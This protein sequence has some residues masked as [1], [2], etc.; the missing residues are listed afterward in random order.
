MLNKLRG[1]FNYDAASTST[2][3]RNVTTTIK[4]TDDLLTPEKRQRLISNANDLQR[5]YSIAAW[6]IRRHLDYVS[7]FTFHPKTGNGPLDADIRDLMG[8]YERAPNCDV[9]ERHTLCRLV[10]LLE[11]R[12]TIDGDVFVVRRGDGR[13]QAV[14]SDRV[15]N[16]P[17]ADAN[18]KHG[19]KLSDAGAMTQIAVHKR[20]SFGGYV[21]DRNV[22]GRNVQ[23][24][25]YFDRL[26]QVRGVSPLASAINSFRD[27]LE[28]SEFALLKMK[29]SALMGLVFYR[30]DYGSL[31]GVSEDADEDDASGPRYSVDFARG[32]TLVLDLDPG[33]KA[34][35]LE[36]RTPSTEFQNFLN[37]SIAA[38]LRALDMSFLFYD[39]SQSNYSSIRAAQIDYEASCKSKRQDLKEFLDRLTWWRLNLWIAE[40][41]LTLPRGMEPSDL[42]WVWIPEGRS[43]VD[44]GKEIRADL[45]A[46]AGGL[47]T[48]AQVRAERYGDNWEDVV[49][50]LANENDLMRELGLPIQ[51]GNQ[52]VIAE[53][54]DGE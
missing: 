5:N 20:N 46:I 35:L 33:D 8:W 9:T 32:N 13:L 53:T 41:V 10:R 36:S 38:A 54:S 16:P 43:W 47:K 24:L 52:A 40:G 1:L 28:A 49:I 27:C 39:Q 26:D 31:G 2:K 51:T 21:F 12:R 42:N 22:A 45:D 7:S 6:A 50:A 30:E 29:V 44:P 34:E 11:A 3:R 15:R 23:H 18:W 48:R 25:A 19:V 17:E 14:E 37:Q 4:S